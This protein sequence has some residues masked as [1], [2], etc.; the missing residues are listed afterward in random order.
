MKIPAPK[1]A[2]DS[3]VLCMMPEFSEEDEFL[4]SE[5]KCVQAKIVGAYYDNKLNIWCYE[6]S[7]LDFNVNDTNITVENVKKITENKI[8]DTFNN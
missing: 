8:L 3:I 1:Y 2:I 5:G 6:I 4:D 7:Y